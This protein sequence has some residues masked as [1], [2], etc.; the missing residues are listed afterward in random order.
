MFRKTAILAAM[1]GG[2]LLIGGALPSVADARSECA[3]R[4]REA[5]RNLQREIERHGEHGRDV[6]RLRREFERQRHE[7]RMYEKD[8]DRHEDRD[9]R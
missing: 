8:R 2:A 4:V 1:L 5:E 9:R 6:E 7:C 3:R